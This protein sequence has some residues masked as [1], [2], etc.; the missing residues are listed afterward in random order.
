MH[1]RLT[2]LPA[3]LQF[4]VLMGS[5]RHLQLNPAHSNQLA[6]DCLEETVQRKRGPNVICHF[7][8]EFRLL[9]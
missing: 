8:V 1:A 9:C 7:G 4:C 5:S 6:F 3:L 2:A